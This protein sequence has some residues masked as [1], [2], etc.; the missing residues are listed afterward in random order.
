MIGWFVLKR[1]IKLIANLFITKYLSLKTNSRVNSLSNLNFNT[2]LEGRNVIHKN[3]SISSSKI[4][5]GTYIG[6]GSLLLNSDIGKYCS[7]AENV[8][9]IFG[10]H[11]TNT[12][13]ST[14]PAFFSTRKQAGFT[15][16]DKS[17]FNENKY[18]D[19]AKK[20]SVKIG[21]DVWIGANVSILEGVNIGNGAI[22]ATG[23]VV[24]TDLE[25][26]AIYG[27]VPAKKIRT[28]FN[29]EA[30][31]FLLDF[32]WWDKDPKWIEENAYFFSNIEKFIEIIKNQSIKREGNI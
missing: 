27:G 23:A 14:H 19:P 26:Y 5:Y 9:I 32:R 8:R 12:F 30:E 10:Q 18:A 7:I 28:R 17:L 22:I 6:D 11:P 20:Y 16:V 24:V 21:N 3:V 29:S 4:G 15:Y 2:I 1:I 25:P 31:A 13:V